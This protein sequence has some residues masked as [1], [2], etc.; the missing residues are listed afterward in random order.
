MTRV[1][2]LLVGEGRADLA[3]VE[4]LEKLLIVAGATE[5]AGTAPDLS[6]LAPPPGHRV[7]DK[8]KAALKLD[9]TF[10]AILIH[11]DADSIDAGP[12]IEEI[13][14]AVNEVAPTSR[15]IAVVPVQELEAWLLVDEEAIRRVAGSPSRAQLRLPPPRSVEA[16][17]RPKERLDAVLLEAS[18]LTGRRRAKF[19][20][21]LA[22]KRHLLVRRLEP[23]GPVSEVPAWR[24]LQEDL[25]ALVAELAA[26]G[27]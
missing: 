16:V 26:A 3:L 9:S 22:E 23:T 8:L 24:R 2:F 14:S 4:P 11:R 6:Q 25:R 5:A 21:R 7:T 1:S 19:Q 10:D 15:A 13:R 18:G 27:S 12:R 20:A 17:A